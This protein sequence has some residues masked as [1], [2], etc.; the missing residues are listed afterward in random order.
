EKIGSVE[1]KIADANT[2]IGRNDSDLSRLAE[3][4]EEHDRRRRDAEKAAKVNEGLATRRDA[5]EDLLRLA[6][7]TLSVLE[8]DHVKPVSERMADLFMTI[9]GSHP[10]FEAGV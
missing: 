5:A 9:V 10:D 8:H 4:R 6:R 1:K 2:A 3:L 7:G